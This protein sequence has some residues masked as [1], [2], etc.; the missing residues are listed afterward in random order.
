VE[1]SELDERCLESTQQCLLTLMDCV[2]NLDCVRDMVTLL[3]PSWLIVPWIC[4]FL[5]CPTHST[6]LR[7]FWTV[8]GWWRR[9][10]PL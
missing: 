8:F 2:S 5:G 4:P 10:T 7:R 6:T 9:L 1:C 3:V